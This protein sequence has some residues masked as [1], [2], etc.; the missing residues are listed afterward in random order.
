MKRAELTLNMYAGSKDYIKPYGFAIFDTRGNRH[1]Y[2]LWDWRMLTI[3]GVRKVDR[4]S[5]ERIAKAE[6]W[7][8]L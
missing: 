6:G 5:I 3:W 1:W 4:D 8:G 2:G 7:S